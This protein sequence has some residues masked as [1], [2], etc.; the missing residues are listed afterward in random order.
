MIK[1]LEVT[2][3]FFMTYIPLSTVLWIIEQ[4]TLMEL[5]VIQLIGLIIILCYLVA[6]I[7]LFEYH[8]MKRISNKKSSVPQISYHPNV[9]EFLAFRKLFSKKQEVKKN[10]QT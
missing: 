3:L 5:A 2:M 4:R 10:E 9:D 7:V 1:E 6:S 8:R